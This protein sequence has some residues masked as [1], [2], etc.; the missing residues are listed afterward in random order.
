MREVRRAGR[1]GP[2]ES[3]IARVAVEA[4]T[5]TSTWIRNQIAGL[6]GR[7]AAAGISL[8]VHARPTDEVESYWPGVDLAVLVPVNALIDWPPKVDLVQGLVGELRDRAHLPPVAICPLST[9]KLL[10]RTPR[11]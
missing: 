10:Q 7:A 4:R 8:D 1:A 2:R 9:E 6:E 11:R 3:A 5:Y